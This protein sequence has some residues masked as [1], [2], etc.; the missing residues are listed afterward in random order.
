MKQNVTRF[1]AE[2]LYRPI[3]VCV[4]V[5]G[6][7]LVQL[8]VCLFEAVSSTQ[9]AEASRSV[10]AEANLVEFQNSQD[11]VDIPCLEK[12]ETTTTKGGSLYLVFA[13]LELAM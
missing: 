7:I 11:Y 6:G 5:W 13:V 4:C 1:K 10:W 9:K 8:F 3:H 12:Q 2:Q